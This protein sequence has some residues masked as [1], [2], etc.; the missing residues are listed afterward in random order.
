MAGPVHVV[1][2]VAFSSSLQERRPARPKRPDAVKRSSSEAR[3]PQTASP[4]CEAQPRPVVPQPAQMAG[5]VHDV[6]AGAF[7]SSLQERRP[8]R[9][10]RQDAVKSVNHKPGHHPTGP[11]GRARSPHPAS[12]HPQPPRTAGP[13]H[14]VAAG[15]FSSSLQ[16]RR[17]ARLK[18]WMPSKTLR[19]QQ[20]EAQ[21]IKTPRLANPAHPPHHATNKRPKGRP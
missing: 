17:A 15:A 12:S 5:P 14:V 6:A 21:A 2:A 8:A 13:V 9:P 4:P 10:K 1:A 3:P 18:G 19:S 20:R 11:L 16:E 7:S